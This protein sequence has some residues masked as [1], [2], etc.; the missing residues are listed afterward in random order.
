PT[1]PAISFG[2]A[3]GRKIA[4]VV[5]VGAQGTLTGVGINNV[6]C[7]ASGPMTVEIQRLTLAGL[8]D[9]QTIAA[10]ASSGA[11]FV[12]S[13]APS[14]DLPIGAKFAFVISSPTQ[15]D[16]A[17][18]LATDAYQ[19]GDAY[20]DAG[21]GWQPLA[22]TDG[23]FD[24]PFRTLIQPAL[25]VAYLNRSRGGLSA[26]LLATGKV[27]LAGNDNSAELY[28]PVT[29]ASTPTGSM[30]QQ[31]INHTATLLLNDKV[32][33]AGGRDF[34]GARS[35]TTE[36]YDVATGTFTAGPSMAAAR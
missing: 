8:P 19:G 30:S 32:L 36:L 14:I 4:Q 16:I 5:T 17:N 7:P 25:P 9:G 1:Q 21:T 18:P 12:I 10:G 27:L 33:I 2:G 24:L 23:R 28:D 29:N 26:T 34:S 31:R 6:T 11:F 15:C 13:T 3:G 22:A 35:A 20:V